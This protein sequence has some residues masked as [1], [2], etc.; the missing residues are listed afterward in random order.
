MRNPTPRRRPPAGFTLTE[1]MIALAMTALLLIGISKIFAITSTTISTGQAAAKAM[2]SQRAIQQVLSNDFLGTGP[3]IGSSTYEGGMLPLTNTIDVGYGSPLL[4]I[5]NFRVP[6][7]LN[8]A[9]MAADSIAPADQSTVITPGQYASRSLAIRGTDLDKDG[10]ENTISVAATG[11]TGET[12]PLYFYGDR[13]FRCDT[14]SFFVHGRFES[15]TGT[16][17]QFDTGVKS[18]EAWVYYGHLRTFNSQIA[19]LN[20]V[21]GHG[22][23]GEWLCPTSSLSSVPQPNVNNRFAEQFRLGRYQY[24][25]VEPTDQNGIPG[26]TLVD[27]ASTGLYDHNTVTASGDPTQLSYFVQRNWWNPDFKDTS[28]GASRPTINP[29]NP[30]SGVVV[31]VP[32]TG[33][34][35]IV[36]LDDKTS[37][38]GSAAASTAYFKMQ[39]ARTDVLGV[40]VRQLRERAKFVQQNDVLDPPTP[41]ESDWWQYLP[42]DWSD[43]FFVNPFVSRS[44]YDASTVSA[45]NP[46]SIAQRQQLLCDS[47]SQFV[48]EYA[49]DFVKQNA[50]GTL[51]TSTDDILLRL[52]SRASRKP[53]GVLD[54]VVSN[55]KPSV[56]ET[57]WYGMPRDVDGNG[58]DCR[59]QLIA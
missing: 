4:T 31:Y 22:M 40:G 5:S 1:V 24:L 44:N 39:T 51:D 29:L 16:A 18:N 21:A 32:S 48:V 49:G 50:D 23:P 41:S 57:R 3:D 38:G 36:R 33:A 7:Y 35:E 13:N 17:T 11:V 26:T 9:E 56:R 59:Q 6:T 27:G 55:T 34:N 30:T 42:A 2:R 25:L 43:R 12:I 19:L 14:L 52:A 54:F 37:T 46:R 15:Q 20:N 53:D 45:V 47:C 8:A 10:S 28:V 58:S